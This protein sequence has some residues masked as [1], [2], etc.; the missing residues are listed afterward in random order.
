MALWNR[1]LAATTAGVKAKGKGKKKKKKKGKQRVG[2]WPFGA[3][4]KPPSANF[5]LQKQ[6]I[7]VAPLAEGKKKKKGE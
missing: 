3:S 2:S 4:K 1:F 7:F 6:N 5:L